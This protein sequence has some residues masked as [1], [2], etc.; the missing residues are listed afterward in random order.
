MMTT[1]LS[2]QPLFHPKP[3]PQ[4]WIRVEKSRDNADKYADDKWVEGGGAVVTPKSGGSYVVWPVV[5]AYLTQKGLKSIPTDEALKLAD[6][7]KAVLVDCRP[8][9]QWEKERIAGSVNVPLYRP[10]EGKGQWDTLKR[11]VMAVGLAMTATERNPDFAADA[12]AALGANKRRKLILYCSLGGT[13]TVGMPPWSPDRKKSFKDD[14]E[15]AFGRESRSL[16][17]CY[18]LLEAGWKDVV[19]MEGGLPQ[20]RFEGKP[21]ERGAPQE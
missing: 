11:F 13:L 21:V 17:A 14:P 7:G 5:H 6:A 20:W 16:K 18:E 12:A 19:H 2:N 3:P 15:R 4:R 10:V 8:R 1:V 9:Y